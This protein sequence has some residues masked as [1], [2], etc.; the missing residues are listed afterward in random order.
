MKRGERHVA[1]EEAVSDALHIPQLKLIVVLGRV[2]AHR[3]VRYLGPVRKGSAVH[4]HRL[5]FLSLRE[6]PGLLRS[7]GG[8]ALVG[9][10]VQLIAELHLI[11]RE[12]SS[13]MVYKVVQL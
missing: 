13:P 10:E 9:A 12:H 7:E 3:G 5:E 6:H 4:L 8:I 2:S 11:W 1:G